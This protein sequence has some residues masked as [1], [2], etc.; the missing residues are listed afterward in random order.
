MRDV[1]RVELGAE[2]YTSNL[3]FAGVEASGVGIQLLPT[4]NAIQV[5][6]GIQREL[7]R[8]RKNFPPGLEAQI[9]FDNVVVVRSRSSRC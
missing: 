1:G 3:R 9:A 5:F 8:L 6:T 2:S 7:E 4:A